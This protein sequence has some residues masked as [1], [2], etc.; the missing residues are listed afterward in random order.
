MPI[1][2]ATTFKGLPG[3][4][5][6]AS[7]EFDYSR[8]GNPT[9]T[10][11]QTHLS[12]IQNCKHTFAVATG[13][14]CLDI[15]TR[16]VKPG[17]CI[18]AGDDIYG[19]T[20][21][22]LGLL[23]SNGGITTHHID[24]TNAAILED[25]VKQVL[26]DQQNGGPRLA[27]VL[28]ETP[29]NPLLKV[30]DIRACT[31]AVRKHVDIITAPIVMDNTMMSPA[32][33]RP[34]EMGVDVVYDS[35][36]K[37]LSGHHDLMA[38]VIA[39]ND[40]ALAKTYAFAINSVG[41]ALSPFESFLLLRGLKTLSI[42]LN[43]QQTS[44]QIIAEHLHELGFKTNYPGLASHPGRDIHMSQAKGAGAVISF[45]TEDAALSQKVVGGTRLWGVSVS[46][47]CVNSLI[48]MPCLM[49]HASIDPKVRAARRLPEDLIRLCVGIEDVDDLI[50]DLD[51]SLLAAGAIQRDGS[52]KLIRATPSDGLTPVNG[53]TDE[54]LL[55]A[56]PGKV[57][58]F[59][60]HAVVHGVTALAAAV[61][62]RCYSLVEPRHDGK[63]HLEL[64]DLSVSHTWS[65]SDLP[66][67]AASTGLVID[68]AHPE[69]DAKLLRRI[70][71]TVEHHAGLTESDRSHASC[72]AFLYIYM[73]ILGKPPSNA[74]GQTFTFR[75]LLPIGAGLGSSASYSACVSSALLYTH[76]VLPLPEASKP[77]PAESAH[78]I[79]SYAFL[80]EKVIHGNPSGVDNSV[81]V[82]G[83]SLAFTRASASRN[84]LTKNDSKLLGGATEKKFLLTDT[85]VGR[86]TKS[87][88][89][90]VGKQ[91][92]EEPQRVE[93]ILSEIQSIVEE[94][95]KLLQDGGDEQRLSAL[96]TRNH[97]LLVQLNVSHPSLET[98]RTTLSTQDHGSLAT[99]LT[100]AGGGGCAVSLIPSSIPSSQ[101]Q[102]AIQSLHSLGHKVYE[103][104]VG[105]SGISI[106]SDLTILE[107]GLIG[108]EGESGDVRKS[109]LS[110]RFRE[111][112]AN[113]LERWLEA[114]GKSWSRVVS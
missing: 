24:T 89:A 93:A 34:L 38:G 69:L 57:I 72:V 83:G 39:T 2:Q 101:I 79:N 107:S 10:V 63:I 28:L 37:Y 78:L 36:T 14:A 96:V 8:S 21:R 109:D 40:E 13:M 59:G 32:L 90:S 4:E 12:K 105:G 106:L 74:G 66:W 95:T 108:R 17:E 56:A 49:S 46:F 94:A 53:S 18:I 16:S 61:G 1:Y 33:M 112:D 65:I 19:G 52:G 84:K 23:A 92:Q 3:S 82:F 100:G 70:V 5:N 55:V 42:R 99:K 47:G 15:I 75:S 87:L 80:S 77:I 88:V 7:E 91:L 45:E 43:A 41:N 81:A 62:L 26:K 6:K 51:A 58:L 71:Q 110:T 98:I 11:L 64:P 114:E 113:G 111:M 9:R 22:L 85:G 31:A 29:T 76:K 68:E 54:T 97:E 20:N 73:V 48:S 60:E 104:T 67:D 44:S 27:M 103:T 30:V 35:A 86:D 50:E 102:K 25:T